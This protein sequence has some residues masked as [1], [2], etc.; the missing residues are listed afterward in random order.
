MYNIISLL[1]GL[2]NPITSLKIIYREVSEIVIEEYLTLFVHAE[3]TT[4]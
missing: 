1:P 4:W 2:P 3:D